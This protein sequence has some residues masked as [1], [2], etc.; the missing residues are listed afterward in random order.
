M[1]DCSERVQT[2]HFL[3]AIVLSCRESNSHHRSGSDTD[4]TV[5]SC[6]A[7]RCELLLAVNRPPIGRK[8]SGITRTAVGGGAWREGNGDEGRKELSR[9]E[10][11]VASRQND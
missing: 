10:G 2:S 1:D 5:L 3:P 4:K 8:E 7:R 11:R 6:P 9:G